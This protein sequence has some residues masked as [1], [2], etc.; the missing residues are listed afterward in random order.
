M[1]WLNE[2]EVEEAVRLFRDDEVPNLSAGAQALQALVNW[3]NSHSDG[4]PY[5][6][7]PSQAAKRLQQALYE[8]RMQAYRD[9]VEDISEADLKAALR[10]IKAFLTKQGAN[11]VEVLG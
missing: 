5:W 4:W 1:T 8:A 11:A 2:Y 3:T 6:R 9:R 10:P 7:L